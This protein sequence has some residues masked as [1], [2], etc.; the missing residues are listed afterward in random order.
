VAGAGLKFRV[1]CDFFFVDFRYTRMFLNNVDLT[2]RYTN[3]ELVYQYGHIDND[4]RMDNFALSIG[5]TKSFYKPRKKHQHNPL[6]INNKYNRW[7]EKERNYI[8][9]ETDEDL[10]RELNAAIKDIE[11]QKPSLIE[12]VQRGKTKFDRALDKNKREFSDLKNKR[13]RVEVKYE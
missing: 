12:D 3:N 5:Y 9:K 7:L 2:N 1:G 13:V 4:F 8:K 6:V 11:R 10:K